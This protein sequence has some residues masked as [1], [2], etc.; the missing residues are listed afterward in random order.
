[1]QEGAIGVD[2]GRNIWQNESPVAVIKGIR[3][4]VH[5]GASAKEALELFNDS[6]GKMEELTSR[7]PSRKA[8]R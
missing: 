3:A 2:M 1:M 8:R 7:A 6:K 4:I 5:E